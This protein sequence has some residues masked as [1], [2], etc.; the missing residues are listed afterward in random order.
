MIFV[1]S[2]NG[3]CHNIAEFT[4]AADIEAGANV[5]LQVVLDLAGAAWRTMTS[6][7]DLVTVDSPDT[8]AI[9]RF[10]SEAARLHEVEREDVDRWIVL[11][12]GDGVRRLGIQR[13]VTRSGSIHLDLA[14]ESA[15]FDDELTRLV[16]PRC[17]SSWATPVASRTDRSPTSPTP[18]ATRSTSART[19]ERR[20]SANANGGRSVERPPFGVRIV[21]VIGQ[22]P[23]EVSMNW[24]VTMSS[25]VTPSFGVAPW[26]V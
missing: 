24:L 3:L 17:A 18:T 21:S 22:R 13:G 26:A 6:R 5:L 12:D 23:I 7:F 25:G 20:A 2:V 10:W 4:Q 16:G 1:P 15:S 14:C 9:A 11:A 8:D 19:T